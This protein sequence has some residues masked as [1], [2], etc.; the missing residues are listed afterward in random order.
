MHKR[1]KQLRDHLG[2]SHEHLATVTGLSVERLTLLESGDRPLLDEVIAIADALGVSIDWLL[3][4]GNEQWGA[5][6]LQARRALADH[7]RT[8]PSPQQI[9]LMG[10]TTGERIAYVVEFLRKEA[11]GLMQDWYVS[12][13]LGLTQKSAERL[14]RGELD[15]TTPVVA[16]VSDLAGLP[17]LW[18]RTGDPKA[19]EPR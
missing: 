15:A 9:Q 12:G 5:R 16:R 3:D 10:A 13:W 11:P 6:L 8:L 7:L 2:L 18:M 14:L 4:R 1:V 19:L 17:E